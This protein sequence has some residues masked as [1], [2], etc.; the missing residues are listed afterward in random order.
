V[1]VGVPDAGAEE[2]GGADE[3][4]AGGGVAGGGVDLGDGGEAVG[5]EFGGA[6]DA[7]VAAVV[8]A[9]GEEAFAGADEDEIGHG[10]LLCRGLWLMVLIVAPGCDVFRP[11]LGFGG[12]G[13]P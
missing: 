9:G 1:V 7:P 11:F 5:V 12:R 10:G 4:A 3:D 2:G 8:A 6:V 13:G